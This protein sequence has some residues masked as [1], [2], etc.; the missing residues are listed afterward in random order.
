MRFKRIEWQLA[1]WVEELQNYDTLNCCISL[2]GMMVMQMGY[3]GYLT[4][5]SYVEGVKRE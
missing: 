1:R 5:W 3:L 4:C 2:E